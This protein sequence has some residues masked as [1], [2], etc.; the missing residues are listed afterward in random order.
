MLRIRVVYPYSGLQV[1]GIVIETHNFA[2]N[3]GCSS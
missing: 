2:C 3:V 1:V